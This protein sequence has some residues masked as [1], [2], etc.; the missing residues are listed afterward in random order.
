M[1]LS[2]SCVAA[3]SSSTSV[4]AAATA[5]AAAA[6]DDEEDG[7]TGEGGRFDS[8]LAGLFW[9]RFFRALDE[10]GAVAAAGVA[11]AALALIIVLKKRQPSLNVSKKKR[12]LWESGRLRREV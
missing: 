8:D 2:E 6:A 1:V 3:F 9:P 4:A 7:D 11:L 5:A 10:G 12:G